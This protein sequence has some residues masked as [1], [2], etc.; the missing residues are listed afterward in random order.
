MSEKKVI[1]LDLTRIPARPV[2]NEGF[3]RHK[4][5]LVDEKTRTLECD[6]CGQVIDPYDFM[7]EWAIGDR[8]LEI[9]KQALKD[10]VTRLRQEVENLKREEQNARTRLRRLNK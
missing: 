3:C 10:E 1:Q 2:R 6:A 9:T 8:K 7:W 5:V 4:Y